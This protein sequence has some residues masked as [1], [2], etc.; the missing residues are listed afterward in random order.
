[1]E[2]YPSFAS[3][4]KDMIKSQL[5][6]VV[7]HMPV[8]GEGIKRKKYGSRPI[9]STEEGRSVLKQAIING[10]PYMAARFG[11]SE[12]A[13]FVYY[14]ET[15]LKYGD[16]YSKYPQ[17][18]LDQIC[19][20]SGFFPNSK[21][22]LWKWAELETAACK[23]LDL[24]G[25]MQFVNE[26]WLVNNFCPQATLMPNGGL[27]SSAHGWA[28][29]LEGRKV[30]V[31][32][33]FTDTI[34]KQYENNREKIFPGTNALPK[35]KLS[36][37]KAVQTIADQ[38]D[39]R[40]ATWF[41][42]LDYMTDEVAKQDFDVALIGCGAYGFQLASR[43]KQMGKIAVHMGSTVQTLFGIK[44][45]RWNPQYAKIM[46]NDAWV[47]PSEHETPKGYEKVENGAY[48]KPRNEVVK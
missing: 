27:G 4:E 30:L 41:D 37:V 28:P 26:E 22:D 6:R 12:G 47:Y 19:T 15:K 48:W 31:V 40:F 18:N 11:T 29:V 35:F 23:D 34:R 7:R 24:L 3:F 39:K 5:F 8:I 36:C 14:W 25:V 10:K 38:E 16:D 21:V 45:A 44:G 13:A 1:M 9:L 32:H 46:Y 2:K 42:A 43:I 17:F 20:L 33:P